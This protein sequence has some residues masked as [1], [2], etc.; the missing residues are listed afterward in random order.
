MAITKAIKKLLQSFLKKS[1][2]KSNNI[3]ILSRKRKRKKE[4]EILYAQKKMIDDY[5][6]NAELTVSQI[7]MLQQFS[8]VISHW[9]PLICEGLE[10]KGVMP[11]LFT[12]NRFLMRGRRF[13]LLT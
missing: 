4:N 9:S 10:V 8:I 7:F 3:L 13:N 2:T 11:A 6:V 1:Q 12:T 5:L